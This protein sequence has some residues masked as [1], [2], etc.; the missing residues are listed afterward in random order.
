MK[1]LIILLLL[2]HILFAQNIIHTIPLPLQKKL[3]DQLAHNSNRC[4][5]G[6]TIEYFK[7]AKLTNGNLLLFVYLNE[8]STTNIAKPINSTLVVVDHL[9]R[10]IS[11][12]GENIISE[13]IKSIHQ[14]PHG[15]IWI[16]TLWQIEGVSPAY[17]HSVNGL[18]W[19]RTVLPKNRNVDCCFESVDAPTFLYNTITLTFRDLDNKTVKSWA[20]NY[21][22]AMSNQPI[23]QPIIKVPISNIVSLENLTWEAQKTNGKMTFFNTQTNQKVYLNRQSTQKEK[24]HKIQVGAYAKESSAHKVQKALGTIYHPI[25]TEQS[26]KYTKLF[27]GKFNTLK[28]A[29]FILTKLRRENPNNKTLQKAFILTSKP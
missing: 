12:V 29:K 11:T 14:D 26:E 27:I 17:Y 24:S 2:S 23:W 9:G 1:K 19:K 16:R 21:K 15:G 7:H 5:N 20:A 10:W 18:R 13:E 6:S 28:K 4:E 3:C 8:H 22:S 25:Y